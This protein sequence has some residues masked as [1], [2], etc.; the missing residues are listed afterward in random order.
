MA[1]NCD[2]LALLDSIPYEK[3]KDP[4]TARKIAELIAAKAAAKQEAS[5]RFQEQSV[6]LNE[7]MFKPQMDQQAQQQTPQSQ[8]APQGVAP[9][10]QDVAGSPNIGELM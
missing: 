6:E 5:V 2:I 7:K 10:A 8:N 9:S 4:S 1:E 3:R